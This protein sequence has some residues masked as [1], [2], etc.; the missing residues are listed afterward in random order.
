VYEMLTGEPPHS[1]ATAQAIV[2]RILTDRP[3]SVRVLRP[4]VPEQV[5][6]AADKALEKVPADRWSSARH[7]ADALNGRLPIEKIDSDDRR[8]E[9][10]VQGSV[11]ANL[12][13]LV[14]TVAAIVL[15]TVSTVG[16]WRAAR[17]S[18]EAVVAFAM[19]LP[20]DVALSEGWDFPI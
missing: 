4:S 9:S 3:R 12:R 13:M 15:A 1:G 10:T 5:A 8:T 6:R 20:P 17:S 11:R 19:G 14:L 16:W 7:F 18:T 2:A